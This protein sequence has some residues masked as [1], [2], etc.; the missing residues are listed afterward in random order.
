MPLDS[1][2]LLPLRFLP[3]M[4]TEASPD[5]QVMYAPISKEMLLLSRFLKEE[6]SSLEPFLWQ[7]LQHI[8]RF[9]GKQIRPALLFL[10]SKLSRGEGRGDSNGNGRVEPTGDA[11]EDHVKIGA[12]V[13]LIHTATL[14]HDDI[15]DDARL[16]RNL[17]TIHCRWGERA[18]VLMGD[19]IYSRAFNIST[20][21]PGMARILSD[22]THTICEGELLQIGN[23]YRPDIGE[24]TYFE[25]IRKKTAV[26]YAV[27]CELGGVL[28]GLDVGRC[29][30][31]HSFGMN[32]GM[33]F[34]IVDDCL[35]YAGKESVTGK[36]LGTDLHQGKVTLPLI[37]LMECLTES[38]SWWLRDVLQ[39][40]LTREA[41]A[42]I[43]AL[44]ESHGVVQDAFARAEA[45]VQ[46]GKAILAEVTNGET[47]LAPIRES[48][49]LVSDYVVRRQR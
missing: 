32:L 38:E 11:I 44:V 29:K 23:R 3:D 33:A 14:I 34:Q 36:S 18:A 28:G 24:A 39:K 21:V 49:E 4:D 48:L 2:S 20:E 41:E 30:R 8:A 22:T 26:L 19:Y 45:F 42:R 27:S 37:Y 7:I 15:L 43:N 35:D 6:F 10:V 9:R 31:L 16:R 47:S 1:S 12:V 13:E 25:I 17:E 46:G 40:P 5:L